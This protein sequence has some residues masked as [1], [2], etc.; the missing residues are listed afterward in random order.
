MSLETVGTKHWRKISSSYFKTFLTDSALQA[1][2]WTLL[3]ICIL[4]TQTPSLYTLRLRNPCLTEVGTRRVQIITSPEIWLVSIEKILW[5]LENLAEPVSVPCLSGSCLFHLR[6]FLTRLN[7][8]SFVTKVSE[9]V[10]WLL[11]LYGH[12]YT[13]VGV[14]LKTDTKR[15]VFLQK[16]RT[17]MRSKY[18][19]QSRLK[20]LVMIHGRHLWTPMFILEG[21]QISL[22]LGL[23]SPSTSPYW[24]PKFRVCGLIA[25]Y[26]EH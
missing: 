18:V 13:G 15:H 24:Q 19:N 12:Q 2:T 16:N 8:L 6:C 10:M 25:S 14:D 20:S 22:Q 3:A 26:N 23:T 9:S 4:L 5:K 7:N 17:N 11:L 21:L 1:Q